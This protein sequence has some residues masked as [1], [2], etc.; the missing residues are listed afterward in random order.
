RQCILAGGHGDVIGVLPLVQAICLL[1]VLVRLLRVEPADEREQGRLA[2]VAG[3]ALAFITAAIPLQLDRQWITI[4][5]ALEGA[6]LAWLYRRIPHRGLLAWCAGLCVAVFIRLSF[7]PAVFEYHARGTLPIWNWYLYTYLVAA[8]A[9][10]ATARLLRDTNDRSDDLLEYLGLPKLPRLS[11]ILPAGGTILLFLLLNIEI[12]DFYSTGRA[13]TF[14]FSAGLAQ[15]LTYTL[16]W[17]MFAIGTLAI[18]IRRHSRVTRI[19]S[20]ALLVV[21]VVKCFLHDLWRLGGLYRVGSFVGLA[22]CLALVAVLLQRFVLGAQ[23]EAA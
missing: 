23:R 10:F 4:G 8:A 16:G 3:A 6:A 9:L 12:A 17:A 15:D 22:I 1:G 18:G 14:N 5:W 7:N 2:L 13:L 20:L 11:D 19:A 21:T